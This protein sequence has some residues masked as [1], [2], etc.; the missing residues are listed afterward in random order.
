M[1]CK[2]HYIDYNDSLSFNNL[3]KAKQLSLRKWLTGISEILWLNNLATFCK[4][5]SISNKF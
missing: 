1:Q 5:P 3:Q 2:V 4:E